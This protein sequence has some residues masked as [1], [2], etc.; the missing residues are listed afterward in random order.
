MVPRVDRQHHFG[1]VPIS[2]LR[3]KAGDVRR[4]SGR[5]DF[6][7]PALPRES[8]QY[9]PNWADMQR[10]LADAETENR[11]DTRD[12]AILLSVAVYWKCVAGK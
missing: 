4:Q 9:A 12:R 3:R 1:S 7:S 10:V 8:L 2:A 5:I 11:R 6:P